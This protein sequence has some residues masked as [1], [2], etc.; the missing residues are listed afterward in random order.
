[1]EFIFY[2]V[3]SYVVILN[4]LSSFFCSFFSVTCTV[5]FAGDVFYGVKNDSRWGRCLVDDF[6]VGGCNTSFTIGTVVWYCFYSCWGFWNWIYYAET[7]GLETCAAAVVPEIAPC[8]KRSS[9]IF[10]FFYVFK[11]IP[12]G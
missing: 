6:N 2:Y 5:D 3:K 4:W 11:V 1:M 8:D 7:V 10:D 12:K 9:S